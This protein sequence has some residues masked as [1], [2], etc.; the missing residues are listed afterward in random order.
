MRNGLLDDE[1]GEVGLLRLAFLLG[2]RRRPEGHTH[3]G[4]RTAD[5]RHERGTEGDMSGM[6]YR[7]NMTL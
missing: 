3:L 5:V 4:H 1:L 7:K 6:G 2:H